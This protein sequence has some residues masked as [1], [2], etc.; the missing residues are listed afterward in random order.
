MAVMSEQEAEI[1]S[2]KSRDQ[3]L[4]TQMKAWLGGAASLIAFGVIS[5]GWHKPVTLC[6]AGAFVLSFLILLFY[7]YLHRRMP[8]LKKPVDL[9]KTI[10]LDDLLLFLGLAALTV[11]LW[12]KSLVWWGIAVLYTAYIFMAAS[13]GINLGA[14]LRE[15]LKDSGFVK[16]CRA[17]LSVGS[18]FL[19]LMLILIWA[20]VLL[21]IGVPILSTIVVL[22]VVVYGIIGI[23]LGTGYLTGMIR[24]GLLILWGKLKAWPQSDW[25]K[26]NGEMVGI[27]LVILGIIPLL[28]YLG[29][30]LSHKHP[31]SDLVGISLGLISVGL[32]FYALGMAAKT[33]TRYT[34]VLKRLDENLARL[35]LMFRNDILT[36]SG[37]LAAE[38]MISE[39]SRDVAQKRLDEDT[40]K[41][42][43]LRGEVYKRGDGIWGIHWGGKYPL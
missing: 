43:Y 5:T 33:D 18:R 40:K 31:G 28:A 39:Q 20:A 22:A 23:I 24:S 25:V 14:G 9:L 2:Q 7:R 6:F 4:R 26:V 21:S 41:V 42:G 16:W 1:E 13:I 8:W 38:E 30:S 17:L 11:A 10:E 12:Q 15:I 19:A 34:K 36:P 3:V 37:Q 29:L 32:G 27:C 35:P